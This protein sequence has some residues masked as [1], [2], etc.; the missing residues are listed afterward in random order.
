MTYAQVLAYIAAIGKDNIVA[1]IIDNNRRAVRRRLAD[2]TTIEPFDTRF[3]LD[4]VL[5]ALVVLDTD[6]MGVEFK[7]YTPVDH[8]QTI[9]AVVNPADAARLDKRYSIG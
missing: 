3:E 6:I 7:T 2:G 8:V 9:V 1:F 4:P 5:E